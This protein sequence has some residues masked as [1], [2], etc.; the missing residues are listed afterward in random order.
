MQGVTASSD[1]CG[2]DLSAHTIFTPGSS[3]AGTG[4]WS[5]FDV[6]HNCLK[7]KNRDVSVTLFD[8]YLQV[9]EGL[10]RWL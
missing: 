8:V 5:K 7:V 1:L 6:I 10:W 4:I 2:E 3:A 9:T